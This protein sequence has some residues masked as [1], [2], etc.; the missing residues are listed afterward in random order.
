M[1]IDEGCIDHNA[2]ELIK[3]EVGVPYEYINKDDG[4]MQ[5]FTIGYIYGVTR[6]ANT[7][8]EVLMENE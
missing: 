8:K 1:R 3:E 2:L 4:T 5:I 6:L 7:L